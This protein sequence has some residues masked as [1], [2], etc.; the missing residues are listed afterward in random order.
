MTNDESS[1][2]AKRQTEEELTSSLNN[3][4]S[5]NVEWLLKLGSNHI[6]SVTW[7]KDPKAIIVT[8]T[9]NI[10]K[11]RTD[12][13]PDGKAAFDALQEVVLDLFPE[14]TLANRN[15]RSKLKFLRVPLQH[16]DRLPM[17]NGLL[18]HYIRKHPNF[19]TVRFLLTPCFEHLCPLKPGQT[20]RTEYTRMVVC[21]IFDT[22]T[23]SVAKKCLNQAKTKRI[24]KYAKDGTTQLNFANPKCTTA[25]DAG[26]PTPQQCT[27]QLAPNAQ[28]EHYVRSNV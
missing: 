27:S 17:D 12:D 10:D 24:V 25:P 8:M 13:L 15:P 3:V 5:E 9:R 22:E 23:G 1:L 20:P 2:L 7:S 6:K 4:I 26:D 14:A 21:E 11:N 18:Y 28:V 19:K 16:S